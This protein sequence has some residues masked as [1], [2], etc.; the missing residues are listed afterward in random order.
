MSKD[1]LTALIVFAVIFLIPII[2]L[3]VFIPLGIRRKQY[4]NFVL[5]NSAPIRMLD[6][7]N[8]EAK[9]KDS[10]RRVVKE[11]LDNERMFNNVSCTDYLIAYLE[12]KSKDVYLEIQR[13][14]ETKKLYSEYIE[15][16]KSING[17]GTFCVD[18]GDFKIDKLKKMER[19][20]FDSRII[21]CR[22]EYTITICLYYE[23]MAGKL[24]DSKGVRFP[25]NTILKYLDKLSDKCG[26]FYNDREIWDA[27]CRVERAKVTNKMRFSIYKRDG[28]RCRICGRSGTS[29]NLE[30]DHIK[31]IAKGGKSTYSN[32]QTLCHRCNARKGDSWDGK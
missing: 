5:K 15:N 28:Y 31:P 3:A 6:N 23:N 12:R 10:T 25:A 17:F 18:I 22:T 26:K 30:I 11:T 27:L 16:V 13:S 14:F 8:K 2:L 29:N 24:R 4:R 32:L 9:F 20:M 19:K 1:E 7:I 21:K